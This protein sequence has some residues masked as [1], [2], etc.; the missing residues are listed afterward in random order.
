MEVLS[1]LAMTSSRRLHNLAERKAGRLGHDTTR[2][3]QSRKNLENAGYG[4]CLIT[5]ALLL[6]GKRHVRENVREAT[7]H[8]LLVVGWPR[9]SR[10][11]IYSIRGPITVAI[12]GSLNEPV[13]AW[14]ERLHTY[15]LS[16]F[17]KVLMPALGGM[18]PA[19]AC[20]L[21]HYV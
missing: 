13:F 16:A 7:L 14:R 5:R 11:Q 15:G 4:L 17:R 1:L 9:S 20:V 21:I 12:L 2:N 10:K 18:W 8:G 6:S 3:E 19:Y